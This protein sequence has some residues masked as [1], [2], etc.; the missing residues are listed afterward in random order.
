MKSSISSI[1]VMIII[2]LSSILLNG[3][4]YIYFHLGGLIYF[5]LKLPKFFRL[6]IYI[7]FVILYLV[8]LFFLSLKN[9]F[10]FEDILRDFIYILK[11]FVS[12]L[13]GFQLS[14]LKNSQEI[15]INSVVIASLVYFIVFFTQAA[16]L[17]INLSG[18]NIQYWRTS[19]GA[20]ELIIPIL[21]ILIHSGIFFYKKLISKKIILL[22][23]YAQLLVTFS[24]VS[25]LFIIIYHL[26]H[27][28][29][30]S[31]LK[32]L[33]AKLRLGMYLALISLFF[34]SL[35]S[36]LEINFINKIA[37]SLK[38]ITAVDTSDIVVASTYWRGFELFLVLEDLKTYSLLDLIFGKGLGYQLQLPFEIK[39]AGNNYRE[40]WY[41]HNGYLY[42]F[43][44]LGFIG[45]IILCW[46]LLKFYNACLENGNS[47]TFLNSLF[48][49][50]I[51]STIV[52]A[53]P[54]ESN[55]YAG[56]LIFM[57]YIFSK[58]L[59]KTTSYE[60]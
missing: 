33:N 6:N 7:F 21:I 29:S 50:T 36:F 58:P 30:I 57:G 42:L 31:G 54:F 14:K 2:F 44:K 20:G 9:G 12:F 10:E 52:M 53:G 5:F 4:F 60:I 39:L 32:G 46:L 41:V 28:F 49:F 40:L 56:I 11:P 48:L 1:F 3:I 51:L 43:M 13:L 22:T 8:I 17:S 25:L 24:R 47:K 16:F 26:I 27:A 15:L 38:E 23:L 37:G 34:I 45:L 35:S 59:K 55:D 18:L 19:L